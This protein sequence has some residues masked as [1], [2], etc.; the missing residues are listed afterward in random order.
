MVKLSRNRKVLIHLILII[1]SFITLGPFIWMTLTAFKTYAEATSIPPTFLPGQWNLNNFRE[2]FE[3]LP[4]LKLYR[5]TIIFTLVATLA[6]VI[7]CSLAGFVFARIDF[8]GKNILFLVVLSVLMVPSQIFIIPQFQIITRLQLGNTITALILPNMFS[9]FGTF[10]MRQ[11]FMSI[12]MEVEEAAIIDGLNYFEIFWKIELPLVKSG[13]IA[14][15]IS[16]ALFCWNT[17]M[18]PLIV[19]TDINLMT[20]SAGLANMQGQHATDYPVLMAGA[21]LAIWPMILVFIIFQRQFI[22]GIATTGTKG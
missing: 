21:I 13:I 15:A 18:W 5:N 10:L 2:A 4:F 12:P 20:L 1:G 14:L 3:T 7:F 6:Q 17:L 11:F 19:N 9:A 16:T 22:E 8:R